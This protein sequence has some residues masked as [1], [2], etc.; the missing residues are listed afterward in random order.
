MENNYWQP[1]GEKQVIWKVDLRIWRHI[2]QHLLGFL[3]FDLLN[4][5]FVLTPFKFFIGVYFNPSICIV[6]M[7]TYINRDINKALLCSIISSFLKS[8]S[9]MARILETQLF[10]PVIL[11][12]NTLSDSDFWKENFELAIRVAIQIAFAQR[13]QS[14]VLVISQR[15]GAAIWETGRPTGE[16]S[17]LDVVARVHA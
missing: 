1:G 7:F 2:H 4:L 3:L 6:L 12:C 9:L 14:Y 16:V 15:W 17:T 8:R 11:F 13:W 5:K 10:I